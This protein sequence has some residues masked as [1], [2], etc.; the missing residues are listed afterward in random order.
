MKINLKLGIG[1]LLAAILLASM[2]YVPMVSAQNDRTN[3][4]SIVHI[5]GITEK[6]TN[7]Y[8][9]SELKIPTSIKK[10]DIVILN[11]KKLDGLLKVGAKVPIHIKGK[12]YTMELNEIKV[13][14][15]GVE[16]GTLSYSGSIIGVNNSEIVMTFS[17]RSLVGRITMNKVEYTIESMGGKKDAINTERVLHVVYSSEDVVAEG[18]TTPVDYKPS[19]PDIENNSANLMVNLQNQNIIIQGVVNVGVLVATDNK[20]VTDEPDWMVKAQNIIAEANNQLSRNDIQV[21]LIVTAYDDS[22][23]YELSNDPNIISAP[24]QT[25]Y[26]HFPTSYLDSKSADIAV[27]LGGY[28]STAG[29]VGASWGYDSGTPALRRYAWAQMADDPSS[30]DAV[31]HDRTVITMH[32]IGHLF[33]ADH[34]DATGQQETYNRAYQWGLIWK[35]QT[36]VWSYFSKDTTYEYSSDNYHGDVNHD[37]ARR[38]SETKGTVSNYKP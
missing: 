32:E 1:A 22:K 8:N 37:N 20:W 26:N 25:F 33:D 19:L 31:H 13:N 29:G 34:Q 27:Y 21:Y 30:Y 9:Q 6:R 18:G 12:P 17:D 4:M 38:I 28:D 11:L 10:S 16:D 14:A 36:V 35:S 3:E 7:T 23:K 24:L 5:D 2:M 15:P